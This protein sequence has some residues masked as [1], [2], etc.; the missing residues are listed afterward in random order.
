MFILFKNETSR[1]S[2]ETVLLVITADCLSSCR[3]LDTTLVDVE[4]LVDLLL[5][6]ITEKASDATIE[7]VDLVED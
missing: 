4:L 5:H 6:K 2:I 7:A 3:C 1:C